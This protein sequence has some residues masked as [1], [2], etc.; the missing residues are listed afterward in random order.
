MACVVEELK[1]AKVR[2]VTTLQMS[3]DEEVKYTGENIKYG[4][5]WKLQEAARMAEEHL[6]HQD[7]V[8]HVCQ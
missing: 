4:R 3:S 1:V 2:A 5:N 7:I 8:G 6:K